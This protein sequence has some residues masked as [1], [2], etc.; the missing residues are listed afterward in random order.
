MCQR[1]TP[2][3]AA[4]M[5]QR[6]A[7]EEGFAAITQQQLDAAGTRLA[8]LQE[9]SRQPHGALWA[10]H[11]PW[12]FYPSRSSS[13]TLLDGASPLSVQVFRCS[14][15]QH[16]HRGAAHSSACD[17]STAAP[18]TS[19]SRGETGGYSLIASMKAARV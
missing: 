12:K 16:R 4:S 3:D 11:I 14:F 18:L 6:R 5:L 13:Q 1:A 15:V 2:T 7:W 10:P 9:G 19:A 8:R 17:C